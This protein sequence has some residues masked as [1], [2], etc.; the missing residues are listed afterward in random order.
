[1]ENIADHILVRD[2]GLDAT[3]KLDRNT[4]NLVS[5]RKIPHH[6]GAGGEDDFTTKEAFHR[7]MKRNNNKK[8][9]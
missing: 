1:M 4:I 7:Q 2:V 3:G 5:N 8:K 6:Q 9:R